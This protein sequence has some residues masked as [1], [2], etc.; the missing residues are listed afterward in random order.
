MW[1]S[2]LIANRA[3][4]MSGGSGSD[5]IYN[6]WGTMGAFFAPIILV[7]FSL[8]AVKDANK[9]SGV[10]VAVNTFMTTATELCMF[11][12]SEASMLNYARIS[13]SARDYAAA[14]IVMLLLNFAALC[15]FFYCKSI[16]TSGF[17]CRF[18]CAA[19]LAG[20]ITAMQWFL[21]SRTRYRFTEITKGSPLI[22]SRKAQIL[23]PALLVRGSLRYSLASV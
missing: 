12:I 17:R 21:K 20:S 10:E 18:V 23:V 6:V 5:P 13:I 14:L 3:I 9:F 4:E 15:L 22:L 11:F 1:S 19:F 2:H 8:Y 7:G 16:W